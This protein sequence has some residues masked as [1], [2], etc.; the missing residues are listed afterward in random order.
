MSS[1]ILWRKSVMKIP[2]IASPIVDRR[3]GHPS[4]NDWQ[5]GTST[6]GGDATPARS[7]SFNAYCTW[8]AGERHHGYID[9]ASASSR[10]TAMSNFTVCGH[11]T[12]ADRS[13]GQ[14]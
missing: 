4:G 3:N 10:L 9:T 5:V 14:T 11:Q 6:N 12:Q 2:P 13:G 1:S 7:A 8:R